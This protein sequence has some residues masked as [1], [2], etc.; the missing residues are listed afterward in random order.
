MET[1]PGL[2]K[3]NLFRLPWSMNDNPI[4]WLEVTDVCNLACEGCYRQTIT[5]HKT[6]DEIKDE[7]LFLSVGATQT[8]SR[9][10]AESR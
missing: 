3:R 5:K 9:S 1:Y 7:I 4:A 2:D 10:R 6:L 8:T